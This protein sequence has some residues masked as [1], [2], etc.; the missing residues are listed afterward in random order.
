[1]YQT[2]KHL[3]IIFITRLLPTC[4]RSAVAVS[5]TLQVYWPP[6][7]LKTIDLQPLF[8]MNRICLLLR[9]LFFTLVQCAVAQAQTKTWDKTDEGSGDKAGDIVN[10][11]DGGMGV[12][13]YS[14]LLNCLMKPI[15]CSIWLFCLSVGVAPAQ[16]TTYSTGTNYSCSNFVA[17]SGIALVVEQLN[18]TQFKFYVVKR[19]NTC[20]SGPNGTFSVSSNW[21]LYN[22][23]GQFISS[24]NTINPGNPGF[25]I[26]VSPVTMSSGFTSGTQYYYAQLTS[27]NTTFTT[28]YVS[29]NATTTIPNLTV[30]SNSVSPSTGVQGSTNFTFSASLN[31]VAPSPTPTVDIEFQRPDG[32]SSTVTNITNNGNGNYSWIQTMQLSGTYSYRYIAYQGSRQNAASSW[33]NFT[34]Q[35]PTPTITVTSPTSGNYAIDNSM[36][37]G[38]S[39][40]NVS[41]NVSIEAVRSRDGEKFTIADGVS[42]NGSYSWQ[43]GRATNGAILTAANGTR[44]TTG[45]YYTIKMYQTG[46]TGSPFYSQEFY[47]PSPSITVSS[48][49]NQG[50]TTNSLL[51]VQWT[52][53]NFGGNVSIEILNSS[54]TSIQTIADGIANSG[55]YNWTIPNEFSAGSYK[56][57]VYVTGWGLGAA[58]SSTFTI[59]QPAPSLVMASNV[60]FGTS[61]LQAGNAYT[62]TFSVR[63]D[64]LGAWSGSM[65][66]QIDGLAAS[67]DAGSATII[68]GQT[69]QYTVSYTPATS[70][71]GNTKAV[72][73]RYQTSGTGSSVVVPSQTTTY[74]NIVAAGPPITI[75]DLPASVNWNCSRAIT[76]TSTAGTGNVSIELVRSSDNGSVATLADGIANS[77]SFTWN[78]AQDRLGNNISGLVGGSY[79]IKMYPTGTS[80]QGS[81]SN[82]FTIPSLVVSQPASGQT[83]QTGQVVPISW[84]SSNFCNS[85]VTLEYTD[86]AQTAG[87]TIIEN[88]PNNGSYSWTIPATVAT[89]SYKIKIY[90]PVA[91][92]PSP[93][94]GYSA[95]FTVN[96]LPC[97]NCIT[98]ITLTSFSTQEH[99]CAAQSLCNLGILQAAQ[100]D[101]KQPILRADLAK[102]V[103]LGLIGASATTEAE[104]YDVPFIDVQKLYPGNSVYAKYVKVMSYLEYGDGRSPFDRTRANFLPNDF[105]S[106]QDMIKVLLEAWN[107]DETTAS[108]TSPFSD[109]SNAATNTFYFQYIKKAYDLQLVTGYGNGTFLP[110]NNCT[111]EDA[112]LLLYRLLT[113][114]TITKPTLAQVQDGFFRPGSYR[115]DNMGLG[116]GTDRGNFNHYTKTSFAIDGTVPLLFAHSYNSYATELPLDLFPGYMSLGWTHS[117]NGYLA[118]QGTASD[119]TNARMVVH[120][121]DGTLHYYKLSGASWVCETLGVY[122][123]FSVINSNIAEITTPGKV[124][125]RFEK[126]TGTNGRYYLLTAISDRNT[127]TLTLTNEIGATPPGAALPIPR[128]R[129][130]SDGQGRTLNFSYLSGENY[131]SS[132]SLGGVGAFNGRSVQFG[133][134]TA[135]IDG[136]P[137]RFRDLTS[138]TEPDQ[139]GGIKTTT[140]GYSTSLD[141]RHLLETI[142]LPK[143]NVVKNTYFQR[144]L[145]SS[146]TLNGTA[147]VQKMTTNWQPTYTATGV[148]ST[149]QVSVSDGNGL[150]KTTNTQHNANGLPFA[151]QTTGANPLNLNM[152]YALPGDQTA[153][154]NITQNGTSVAIDYYTTPP[155]NPSVVRTQGPNSTVITQSYSYNSF[156]DIASFTNGRGFTTTFGYNPT[157]NLTAINYP[158]GQPTGI[159]RNPNGTV[160]QLT[161]PA[162]VVTTFGYDR[163]GNLNSSNTAN[164]A[165]PAITTSATYDDLSRL[166]T[167]TDAR[168]NVMSYD[169]FAND[170]IQRLTAPLGYNVTYGYDANNNGTSVT[171]AKGNATTMIYHPQTDQLVSRSFAGQTETFGYYD[172]GSLRTYTN[173]RGNTFA[174]N[175]DATGRVL[176]DSYANYAYNT[177]GTPNTITNT[178]G[179]RT[180]TLDFDYDVLKR[181]S[182]TTCD[183]FAVQYGY[184]QNDNR[185]RLTYPDN[186]AITYGYDAKDRLTSLTDWAGR[187]TT[188]TYDDDGKLLNYVLP[189]G[190]RA[191]MTYDAAGRP[192]GLRHEKSNQTALCAYTYT[193]DQAGNHTGESMVEPYAPT[194]TLPLGTVNYTTDAANRTTQ[195]DT[196]SYG[197]DGNGAVNNQAGQTLT[198]DTR[199]N[200]LTGY[201]TTF[202]YDGNETRRA[203]TARRYV[204]DDLTNSVIAET[205]DAGTYLYFYVHGPTGLL[206]RQNAGTGAVEFYHYDFRGSTI[207]T[208]D[209]SQ[210]IVRKYQYDA[211]GNILQQTPAAN[212]DDNPFRYVGQHGVQYEQ[213]NLYFMRARY[214]DP[215]IGKFLSEDPIW[216]TNLYAYAGNNSIIN[217]DEDGL[218]LK[219]VTKNLLKKTT[220]SINWKQKTLY[221][222]AEKT[223]EVFDKSQEVEKY[224]AIA[225]SKDIKDLA[226]NVAKEGVKD[227]AGGACGGQLAALGASVGAYCGPYAPVCATGLATLGYIGGNL[228]CSELAGRVWDNISNRRDRDT[229]G[230]W[231]REKP[232]SANEFGLRLYQFIQSEGA[233]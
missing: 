127:N 227:L 98:G 68:P 171:N 140:Y 129:A 74:I 23:S 132:V 199:D 111:R 11:N 33:S 25:S 43:T 104:N 169:Y 181:V 202:Y 158:I 94:V 29:I 178:T 86:V 75:S 210:T 214:Y 122:D 13:G 182:Q 6:T 10:T 125:Y 124:T 190:T 12:G 191:L 204:M 220:S 211:Y 137:D 66:V 212:T 206:Y 223:T 123:T 62:A 205:N 58:E 176:A 150:T 155:Y 84:S 115:P 95:A 161:T 93:M 59:V 119:P 30:S 134:N 81:L 80:G 203:K 186:K 120:Y 110:G 179:P 173:K 147:T 180:Y 52:S 35:A 183:G 216:N 143:G 17:G 47:V 4:E 192:T 162:G 69:R 159:G 121:P 108:G 175:Y 112:F 14:A 128:L 168:A 96:G 91:V 105:I 145:R 138:Y 90:V 71:I 46:S 177:D 28:G 64:G 70:N 231:Q 144:K 18:A 67:I 201:G 100:T 136:G 103:Y 163:F 232:K 222:T 131:L 130:V 228:A 139:N 146:E 16:S 189:N 113:K 200:L 1:M 41:G 225:K 88:I 87:Q 229:I 209:A 73:A 55:N 116:I 50:Y 60:S 79:K 34:V 49:V 83:Y 142:T 54:G 32:S 154:T 53:S 165:N 233:Y 101:P 39:S 92:A 42:N 224:T 15:L 172:D 219:S 40:Q 149:G 44:F 167:A 22:S 221:W 78:A 85:V 2:F 48:P 184:D 24:A 72:I 207:A 106:R 126:T 114:P 148:T 9:T 187:Q 118:E 38:W 27:S 208:T 196:R 160:S 31:N 3:N 99:F 102:I 107:I 195:A 63:N 217:S 164:G 166:K 97:P 56:V 26:A 57:K 36:S 188:F 135:P 151:V 141:S 197:F 198:W 215:T 174:F 226:K 61:T 152:V 230:D 133:Y 117:F 20:D 185:N 218:F 157:G 21:T 213:A 82:V 89:G 193:L 7:Y 76:W 19:N 51:P 77:G 45:D 156:N 153:V 65:Y 194:P 170:L 8:A 109:V 5:K 37:I